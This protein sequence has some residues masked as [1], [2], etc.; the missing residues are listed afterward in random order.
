VAHANTVAPDQRHPPGN[1]S[2]LL[3]NGPSYA[4]RSASRSFRLTVPAARMYVAINDAGGTKLRSPL[5]GGTSYVAT[6]IQQ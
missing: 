2:T 6:S 4:A 3:K 1:I 5:A